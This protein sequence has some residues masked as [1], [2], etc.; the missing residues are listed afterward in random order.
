MSKTKKM[1]HAELFSEATKRLYQAVSASE[2]DR[3]QA[4]QD[5]RFYIIPGAQ[6][7]GK[8]GEQ[9]EHRI[10]LENNQVALAIT[11]I[12]N[13]YRNNRIDAKF[14]SKDGTDSEDFADFLAGLYRADKQDSASDEAEDNAFEEAVGGGFGAFRLTNL[15]EDEYDDEDDKQRIRWE[16]ITDA[17]TCV[18]FDHGSIKQDKSD[19]KWCMVLK[20]MTK[21]DF[22]EQWDKEVSSFARPVSD[23]EFDWCVGDLVYVAEYFVYE[24]STY[25]LHYYRDIAG[26]TEKYRDRDLTEEKLRE[27]NTVGTIR[28]ATRKIKTRKVR[29]Y[30]LSGAGVLEDAGH[31]AGRYIPIIPVYGQRHF[32]DG[33]ERFRGHVRITKDMQRLDNMQ[34]SLLAEQAASGG[35]RVPIFTP[36]Q[37]AGL[38]NNW[39]DHAVNRPA[40]QLVNPIL[41][42]DGNEIASG[43]V[44]YTEPAQVPEA[45]AALMQVARESLSRLLGSQEAGENFEGDLSGKAVELIQNRID[46]QSFIYMSNFAKA[47][48]HAAKVWL[49]MAGELYVE[50]DRIMKL[51]DEQGGTD[52]ADISETVLVDG[53]AVK[54]YDI[55][56]AKMDVSINIGPTSQ[57]R[58]AATVRALTEMLPLLADPADQSVVS[59]M[60]LMNID[61]EGIGPVRDHFRKKLV[62]LGLLEPT[63]EEREEMQAAAQ[64]GEQPSPEQTY[65]LSEA[66]QN[67]AD[68][69]EARAN[70]ELKR[71][72]T[73]KTLAEIDLEADANR[74]E[75]AKVLQDAAT[76]LPQ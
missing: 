46:G 1:R 33:K 52:Y 76:T 3:E 36:E 13:E 26:N 5:R 54:K 37:V 19:A 41:D 60:A 32:V 16:P 24:D 20:S 55:A 7:E 47:Q 74:I 51:V 23:T 21:D 31:I 72:Q 67:E 9:F 6:W 61:G 18:Y 57:S 15:Y 73:T 71:A 49:C 14:I 40:F 50:D 8:Y 53:E 68:A 29:K 10:T 62:T 45:T 25:D 43:P 11:R 4:L 75:A 35:E 64:Q 63:D 44:G 30:I 34:L 69:E 22:E 42:K 39:R 28:V 27:L 70:A 48:E 65:M 12:V 58:K 66:A 38:E 2:W 59:S 17:D 56:N